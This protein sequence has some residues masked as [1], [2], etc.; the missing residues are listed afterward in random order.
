VSK[1][2]INLGFKVNCG[3]YDFSL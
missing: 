2:H 3:V 1:V